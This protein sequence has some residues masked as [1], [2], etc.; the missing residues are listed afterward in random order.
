MELLWNLF[1][2]PQPHLKGR[3]WTL[4]QNLNEKGDFRSANEPFT[5]T[6]SKCFDQ[7]ERGSI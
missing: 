7:K 1:F 5:Q 4:F 3:G 6:H 2:P